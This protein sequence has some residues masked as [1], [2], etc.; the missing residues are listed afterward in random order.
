MA[1][2][3]GVLLPL[4]LLAAAGLLVGWRTFWFLTDDAYIAF[5]YVSNSLLGHGYV[6]NAAPFLPVEGYTSFLWVVLL[7]AIWRL[8]GLE[9]PAV[10]NV[11]SLAF[12]FGT[13]ALVVRMALDL[14]LGPRLARA[15]AALLAGVLLGVLTN[16]TF[17][18]WT[19][20]GLETAMFN[21]LVT[22]WVFAGLRLARREAPGHYALFAAAAALLELARPDGL[23][24]AAATLATGALWALGRWRAG[25]LRPAD[26]LAFAPLGSVAAHLAWRR[27]FYGEWLPNTYFAKYAGPWPE[28][29]LRYAWSFVLEYA[30][31]VWL[32]VGLAWLVRS[33]FRARAPRAQAAPTLDMAGFLRSR[34]ALACVIA[35][36]VAQVLYYTFAIGGDH[37]EY[38]VYS[39]IVPFIFLSFAWLLGRLELRAAP[40]LGLFAAFVLLA[41]PIPWLHWSATRGL[42]THRE[43]TLLISPV[44]P[45]LPG[46]LRW[47]GALF[48]D[49]QTWL[50]E[51][52]VCIRHQE[53]K[54]FHEYVTALFGSRK[55]GSRIGPEGLPVYLSSSVG[56]AAW[57]LPHVNVIDVLGLNDYVIAR[58]PPRASSKERFMAHSRW[59]PK[60]YV[61][62]YAPNVVLAFPGVRVEPREVPLTEQQVADSERFWRARARR[63]AKGQS[64]FTQPP[65]TLGS[66]GDRK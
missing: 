16:R 2:R 59:P 52:A 61:P 65:R 1:I 17:L 20:S 15:R 29:G 40:A 63:W 18:A 60:G 53:H 51:H 66:A 47:Y 11:L 58:T 50:I 39:H 34:Y 38:R 31:W 6:W 12:S 46:A 13:L 48:D 54:I 28:S 30:L 8:A 9:P 62:S 4:L 27:A 41:Q 33:A 49:A 14:E 3:I 19:S 44:A 36:L 10:A 21:F 43:T 26:A 64:R 25:R 37:F 55:A 24:F 32:G 22:L 7:E 35:T 42:S 45:R 5:R 23:L 56:V 57:T